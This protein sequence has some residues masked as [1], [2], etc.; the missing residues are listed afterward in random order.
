MKGKEDHQLSVIGSLV[1][2]IPWILRNAD[3]R[4]DECVKSTVDFVKLTHPVPSLFPFVEIY[5]RLI[6]RV[7]HG[8]DLREEVKW[9]LE[10]K[11][12]GGSA[13]YKMVQGLKEKADG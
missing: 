7:L 12:M 13:K 5:A 9:A 11:E 1:P 2:A 4:E 10:R 3:K 6:H 8:K